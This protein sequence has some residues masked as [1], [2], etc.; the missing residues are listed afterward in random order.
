M[1]NLNPKQTKRCCQSSLVRTLK[2]TAADTV[3]LLSQNP[4]SEYS[5]AKTHGQPKPQN[6]SHLT[7]NILDCI[8]NSSNTNEI[9]IHSRN[10]ITLH[11][12]ISQQIRIK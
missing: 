1:A 8:H 3:L 5:A 7:I 9:I 4:K 11:F 6:P 12:V 2:G 10:I